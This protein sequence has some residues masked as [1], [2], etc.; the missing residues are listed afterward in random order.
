MSF[1]VTMRRTLPIRIFLAQVKKELSWK[2]K[3]KWNNENS[4]ND[5]DK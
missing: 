1:V 5:N 2:K 3:K 4:N